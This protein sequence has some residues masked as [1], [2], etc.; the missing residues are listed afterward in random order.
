MT[1]LWR[2]GELLAASVLSGLYWLAFF[3]VAESIV[4]GDYRAGAAPGEGVLALRAGLVLVGGIGGFAL[5]IAIWR[6][7]RGRHAA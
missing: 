4:A 1:R 2:V 6:R 5:C 3:F 7:V